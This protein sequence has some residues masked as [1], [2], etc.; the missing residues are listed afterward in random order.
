ME[1]VNFVSKVAGNRPW[2]INLS[3]GLQGGPHDG[4]TLC[5]MAFDQLLS[6]A[7]NRCIVQSTGNYFNKKIHTSGRLKKG[8]KRRIDLIVKDADL[9]PNEVEIWYSSK[10]E[11]IFR[12]ISPS[13]QTSH[14]VGLGESSDIYEDNML[15]GRMYNRMNDP[16]NLDN[17]FDLFL[18]SNAP[19]GNWKIEIIAKNIMNGV[20]HSWIERDAHPELQAQFVSTNSNNFYTTG[21]IANGFLPIVVGAYDAHSEKREIAPFSSVGPTRDNRSKPDIVAPG[22]GEL[23]A[24]SYTRYVFSIIGLIYTKIWYKHGSTSRDWSRSTLL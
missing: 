8:E 24:K 15:I 16:N 1:A 9:T 5:E 7:P 23:S 12:T 19:P 10:D 14:F 2:V 13:G 6:E 4:F 21:T 18:Y 17:H 11:L 3:V 22:V 20:Y